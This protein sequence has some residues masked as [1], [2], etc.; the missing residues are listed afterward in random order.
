MN[1]PAVPKAFET[2]YRN[3]EKH[4]IAVIPHLMRKPDYSVLLL[5]A[6]IK[7]EHDKISD[8]FLPRKPSFEEF[9]D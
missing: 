5:D 9:F 3:T 2:R 8:P 6:P 4:K 1:Y 7:S